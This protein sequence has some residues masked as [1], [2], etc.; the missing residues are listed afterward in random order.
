MTLLRLFVRFDELGILS[1]LREAYQDVSYHLSTED[2]ETLDTPG[3]L[4]LS[5][6]FLDCIKFS[7]LESNVHIA[8]RNLRHS[9]SS[10]P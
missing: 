1:P 7:S 3:F 9:P 5:S 10:L 4:I 6:I 2:K 8:P